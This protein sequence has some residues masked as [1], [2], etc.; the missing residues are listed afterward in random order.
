M[1][2]AFKGRLPNAI[3]ECEIKS[4]KLDLNNEIGG[5]KYV[6]CFDHDLADRDPPD[7][8]VPICVL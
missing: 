5:D 3:T 6:T 7:Q 1:I 8:H 4:Q 2:S